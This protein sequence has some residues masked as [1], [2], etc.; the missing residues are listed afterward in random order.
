VRFLRETRL[1]RPGHRSAAERIQHRGPERSGRQTGRVSVLCCQTD[2]HTR[3]HRDIQLPLPSGSK[4]R[5]HSFQGLRQ[6]HRRGV[7]RGAQHRQ[8]VHRL[9]ELPHHGQRSRQSARRTH[10]ARR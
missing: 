6:E 9:A 8:R 4:D 2:A 3:Q 5:R 10:Q 1:P 7:R